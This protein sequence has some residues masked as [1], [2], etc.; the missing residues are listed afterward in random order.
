MFD[1][2]RVARRIGL[3]HK[4]R[5]AMR[6]E[7]KNSIQEIDKHA[8][9]HLCHR[10][11]FCTHE[12][13]CALEASAL[14]CEYIYAL[15]FLDGELVGAAFATLWRITLSRFS[16]RVATMGTPV[17]TG[18]ALLLKPHAQTLE[19]RRKLI[20]SLQKISAVRGIRLFIGRD[21]PA[22][23]Y[24]QPIPLV[25]LYDYAYLNIEWQHF[26]QY[27]DQHPKRKRIRRDMRLLERAGYTLEI[28]EGQPLS[29]EEAKRLYE[30]WL[31]LYRKHRSPDQIMVNP[32]F[33]MRL[34]E[35]NHAV[36]LLLRKDGHID[37]FDLCFILGSQLESTYCGVD[38]KATGR[39]PVHRAMGYHIIRYATEKGL[40]TVNFGISN[41][42]E[43]QEMGCY[44]KTCYSWIEA[45]PRWLGWMFRLLLRFFVLK[46]DAQQLPDV[47]PPR[48]QGDCA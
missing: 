45:N 32:H 2:N 10:E 44:L 46:S 29:E 43:K 42:Q 16:L 35:L 33:F 25:P 17:N 3:R 23:D 31:Q 1:P 11:Q 15:V 26:S 47:E 34:G 48:P 8:W 13:L 5:R 30:L 21:F 20:V 36:W 4:K 18:L 27:L 6:V 39:L 24:V 7:I 38:F 14:D 28:R 22:R 12:Y 41:I 37:A 40:Q 9:N 19:L